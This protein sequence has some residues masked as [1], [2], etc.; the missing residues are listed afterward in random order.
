MTRATAPADGTEA[1]ARV[2]DVL[3][4]VG[5]H[6]GPVGVT[7]LS[8]KLGLGKSV[9]HRI[10]RT[11]EDRMLV[12]VVPGRP[13]RYTIGAAAT[14]WGTSTSAGRDLMAAAAPELRP[15]LQ[16][17]GHTVTLSLLSGAQ[18]RYLAQIAVRGLLMPTDSGLPLHAGASGR[19]ILAFAPR[20][21]HD[22]VFAAGL[23]ALTRG[24]VTDADRLAE[25]LQQVRA[26]LVAV[27]VGEVFP[28]VGGIASPV[29]VAGEALGAIGL[30]VP[31][32]VLTPGRTEELSA[33]VRS[34]ARRISAKVSRRG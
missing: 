2:A 12:G 31:T 33:A 20:G 22:Q 29:L 34:A 19:A 1:A 15:L 23:P 6:G 27:S 26:A 17:T 3:L 18:R 21:V 14:A 30:C 25:E 10:L 9:V 4:A 7:E 11:L 16:R 5:Q 8:L 32:V 13:G 24:T 28:G